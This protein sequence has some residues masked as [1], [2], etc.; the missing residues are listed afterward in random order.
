MFQEFKWLSIKVLC[1]VIVAPL[2]ASSLLY[3][4]E[5]IEHAWKIGNRRKK[6]MALTMLMIF[7]GVCLGWLM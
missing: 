4:I 7:M 6:F 1:L 3:I 2:L 5:K